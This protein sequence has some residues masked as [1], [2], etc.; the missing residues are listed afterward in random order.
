MDRMLYVAMSGA[1]ETLHAQAAVNNNMANANTP[2]FLADLQQF[3][4][5]PV[6]GAG[7]PTRVYAM[8]ERPESDRSPGT[9][10]HTGRDLDIAIKEGGWLAVQGPDGREAYTRR[11][12]LQVD[13][14]GRL[15]TSEGLAVIG[16]S[17]PIALP[18]YEKIEVGAD[19]TIS[20]RPQG[21]ESNQLAVVDRIKL[22]KAS[23]DQLQKGD[24]GLMHA[25]TGADLPADAAVRLASGSLVASNVDLVGEMVSMIEL[26]RRFELQVKMMK[27]AEEA[28]AASATLLRPV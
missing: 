25:R 12:D 22:V 20:I 27:T 26:S 4:S 7:H 16:N 17:G 23:N 14:G 15:V 3:R 2:G 19:G 1:K 28:G 5:M 24:D 21:G 9:L 18:P 6:F 13:P 8:S 11:G 10:D